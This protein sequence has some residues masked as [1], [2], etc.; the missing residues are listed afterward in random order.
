M[1]N[2]GT[3]GDD[4]FRYK[5]EFELAELR[6]KYEHVPM[7]MDVIDGYMR[8]WGW[9][10][11]PIIRQRATTIRSYLDEMEQA[12]H[13]VTQMRELLQRRCGHYLD[14][15]LDSVMSL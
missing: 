13:D 8:L 7:P 6:W 1:P 10:Y 11:K 5:R 12:G 15:T 2:G 14:E 4:F 9:L 3:D